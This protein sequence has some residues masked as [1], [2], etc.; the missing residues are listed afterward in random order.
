M[1]RLDQLGAVVDR[2]LRVAGYK[3]GK[4]LAVLS[5]RLAMD[6][7]NLNSVVI[8]ER[9]G[10]VVLRRERVGRAERNLGASAGEGANEVCGLSRHVQ[11]DR[12]LH[13]LQRPLGC[14]ALSDAAE[15]RHLP[16]RPLDPRQPGGGEGQVCN[17]R[18]GQD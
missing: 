5:E 17:V 10:N 3:R 16:G 1:E 13:A 4:M 18:F 8:D 9:S 2:D 14:E 7:V 15:H 6:R 12:D 11:A